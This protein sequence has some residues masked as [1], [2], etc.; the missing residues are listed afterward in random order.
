LYYAGQGVP[1]DTREALKYF[2]LSAL[3]RNGHAQFNLASIYATGDGVPQD[4]PRALV[5]FMAA[6]SALSGNEAKIATENSNEVASKMT[7]AQKV[8][9][10]ALARDCRAS[11]YQ[12]CD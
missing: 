11:N 4:L 7:Q 10:Q 5:W 9:A 3:Q 6:A 12:K 1:K 2:R 8:Q